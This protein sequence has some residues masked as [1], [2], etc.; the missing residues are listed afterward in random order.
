M[1]ALFLFAF[2]SL[3]KLTFVCHPDA[4]PRNLPFLDHFPK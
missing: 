3:A 2:Q 1:E 4:K